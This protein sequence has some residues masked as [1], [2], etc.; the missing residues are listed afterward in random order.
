MGLEFYYN[1]FFIL[2]TCREVGMAEG[3]I[4]WT[5]VRI[6][7]NDLGL[8]DDEFER[9]L[10]LVNAMDMEYLKYREKQIKKLTSK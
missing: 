5:A 2:N 9:L 7:S 10:T 4:P 6:Y 1:A 3:H 8:D